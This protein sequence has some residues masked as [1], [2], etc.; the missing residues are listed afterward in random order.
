RLQD[1]EL[2]YRRGATPVRSRRSGLSRCLVALIIAASPVAHAEPLDPAHLAR[3]P[4]ETVRDGKAWTFSPLTVAAGEAGCAERRAV[5]RCLVIVAGQP[6]P[7]EIEIRARTA[8]AD[9]LAV[10]IGYAAIALITPANAAA[11]AINSTDLFRAV[12]EHADSQP[13][14]ANWSDVD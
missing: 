4:N 14:P 10:T 8:A 12:A 6:T 5:P 9:I 3:R 7:L 1:V 13:A 11:F 2:N